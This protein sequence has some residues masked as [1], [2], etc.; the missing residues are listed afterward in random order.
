MEGQRRSVTSGGHTV[1]AGRQAPRLWL[2]GGNRALHQTKHLAGLSV[3]PHG[4]LG[5]DPAP[6]HFHLEHTAGRLDQ[7]HVGVR[8]GLADLGRQTGGPR[9]V[10]SDDAVLDRHAH[11]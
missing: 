8:V 11:A 4:L 3:P 2:L 10:V 6:I 7:F 9:L 1:P 5:E